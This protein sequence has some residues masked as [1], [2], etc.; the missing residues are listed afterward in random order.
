MILGRIKY[1]FFLSLLNIF[2]IVF[3]EDKITTVP[4]VNLENLKPSFENEDLEGRSTSEKK[5]IN[6]KEK[7]L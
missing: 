6:L 1:I 4:L 5:S 7:K 2:T 3:A